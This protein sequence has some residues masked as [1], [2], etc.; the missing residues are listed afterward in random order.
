MKKRKALTRFIIVHNALKLGLPGWPRGA[1]GGLQT[2]YYVGS[3]PIPGSK[4]NFMLRDAWS[5]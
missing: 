2:R 1:G 4:I 3:I 5:R